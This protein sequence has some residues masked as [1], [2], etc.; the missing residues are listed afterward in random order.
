MGNDVVLLR[1]LLEIIAQ[2]LLVTSVKAFA[3]TPNVCPDFN[4]TGPFDADNC[5][6]VDASVAPRVLFEEFWRH[7]TYSFLMD[8]K[9]D[10]AYVFHYVPN[11]T[12]KEKQERK[13][14][15]DFEECQ[16]P[17][18]PICGTYVKTCY[19]PGCKFLAGLPTIGTVVPISFFSS[20]PYPYVNEDGAPTIKEDDTFANCEIESQQ[21]ICYEAQI[22]PMPPPPFWYRK[23][24]QVDCSKCMKVNGGAVQTCEGYAKKYPY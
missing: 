14:W 21:T 10:K 18:A 20:P 15:Y 7:N 3:S 23:M 2:L 8:P 9:V 5:A 4:Y 16:G 24:V 13:L 12:S 17:Y 6:V 19:K 22:L 11:L 1:M